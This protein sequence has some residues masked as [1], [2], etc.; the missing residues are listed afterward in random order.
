VTS[1]PWR[2]SGPHIS[3]KP[4]VAFLSVL[5][6]AALAIAA[7]S[8]SSEPTPLESNYP[9]VLGLAHGWCSQEFLEP[10]WGDRAVDA[11]GVCQCESDGVPTAVSDG[12]PYYGLFQI[13]AALHGLDPE[14]LLDPVYNSHIAATLQGQ[15]GWDPWPVCAESLIAA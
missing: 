14:S 10:V 15:D 6:L 2:S 1:D 4:L 12:V 5:T 8:P 13:D 11:S 3:L 9:F 7:S